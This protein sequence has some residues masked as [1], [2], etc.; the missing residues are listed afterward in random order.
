VTSVD[1]ELAKNALMIS[2][3]HCR[4]GAI[5]LLSP[6]KPLNLP[7]SIE[8]LSISPIDFLGYSKFMIEELHQ[9]VDTQFCLVIQADGF[10][11][12]PQLWDT[13]FFEYDYIG[14]PWPSTVRHKSLIDGRLTG[15]F[16]FDKNNV[17]NG[18]FSLRSKK[19]LKLCSEIKF[20][21]LTFGV[22]SEDVII[23][24][25]LYDEMRKS[26]IK[27]AP[28]D[29]ASKF[30]T[31]ILIEEISRDLSESFGFHGKHWLSNDYLAQLANRSQFRNEFLELLEKPPIISKNSAQKRIG[32]LDP[33]PCSS[34]K[35][36]KECHGKIN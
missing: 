25:Y 33:C 3:E 31:E 20:D 15:D 4:F 21:E 13:K 11:I 30:S 28:Q 8:H 29:V 22:K 36:F 35:R 7:S 9:Y 10:V 19:L 26:G 18:G 17:G 27:F 14:A 34:G 6:S 32:R 23:C 5:K 1:V 16:S 24:H 12:N 2:N